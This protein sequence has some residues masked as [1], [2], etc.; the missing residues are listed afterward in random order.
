MPDRFIRDA[1]D[2][3]GLLQGGADIRIRQIQHQPSGTSRYLAHEL[4]CLGQHLFVYR[5]VFRAARAQHTV[6]LDIQPVG[7]THQ[8]LGGESPYRLRGLFF[9]PFVERRRIA[10]DEQPAG[11][12][13]IAGPGQFGQRPMDSQIDQLGI[14]GSTGFRLDLFDGGMQSLRIRC[15]GSLRRI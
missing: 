12:I 2:L 6:D 5:F 1:L 7:G 13:L 4:P 3:G 11:G 15:E 9:K 10:E 14:V 8:L